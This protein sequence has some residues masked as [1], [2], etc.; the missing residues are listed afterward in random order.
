MRGCWGARYQGGEKT[1]KKLKSGSLKKEWKNQRHRET[2]VC[3]KAEC[4]S[5]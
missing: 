2:T 4:V 5:G 1:V 3:E